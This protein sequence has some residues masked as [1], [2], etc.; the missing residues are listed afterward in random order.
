MQERLRGVGRG[1]GIKSPQCRHKL[2]AGKERNEINT[3]ISA[4]IAAGVNKGLIEP[5]FAPKFSDVSSLAIQGIEFIRHCSCSFVF[6]EGKEEHPRRIRSAFMALN[7]RSAKNTLQRCGPDSLASI[8]LTHRRRIH[9]RV[10]PGPEVNARSERP[11]F[12]CQTVFASLAE[13]AN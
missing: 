2:S 12:V 5:E 6:A 1:E 13:Q 3:S 7:L 10:S 9:A 4:V 11:V 8:Y